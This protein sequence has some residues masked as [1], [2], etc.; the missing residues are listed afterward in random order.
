MYELNADELNQVNGGSKI[1]MVVKGVK[2]AYGVTAKAV[3]VAGVLTA[4]GE[5][6]YRGYQWAR[7]NRG[8]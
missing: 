1:G 4:A 6:A 2:A 7:G 3:E 5:L 8:Q